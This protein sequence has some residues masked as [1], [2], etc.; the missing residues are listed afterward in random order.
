M[1]EPSLD[2]WAPDL[3]TTEQ[4]TP[5]AILRQQAA[6][7]GPKT[8]NLL[9][10]AVDTVARGDKFI[11]RF[12]IVAP[13]LDDYRYMLF[14]VSHGMD[15]YPVTTTFRKFQREL[16]TEGGFLEWLKDMLSSEETRRIVST[17]IA[18]TQG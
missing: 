6:L 15:P 2:L 1:P 5:V 9:G 14:E 18:Q 10:G 4:V 3:T 17:L 13:G 8:S 16:D 11:H 7:L 12:Y